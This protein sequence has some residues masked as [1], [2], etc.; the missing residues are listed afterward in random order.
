MRYLLFVL[1][2]ILF[3][4]CPSD[5][6]LGLSGSN[7]NVTRLAIYG[8]DVSVEFIEGQD[9]FANFSENDTSMILQITRTVDPDISF[10]GDEG[11]QTIYIL[12]PIDAQTIDLSGNDWDEITSFAFTNE[13]TVNPPVGRITGG[14]ITGQRL[15]IDNSWII[16]G[17]VELSETFDESF[18]RD[19]SGTF[20]SR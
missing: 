6:D 12:L 4:G 9:N 5:D 17:E 20:S 15:T 2:P 19:L 18:P 10:G 7:I 13:D 14:S 11:F 8:F 1:L 3:F 16:N